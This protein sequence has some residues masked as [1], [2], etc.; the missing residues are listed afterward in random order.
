[1]LAILFVAAGILHFL[2]PQSYLKIMPAFFPAPLALVYL[3][4]AFEIL[5]GIGILVPRLRRWTG[6]GLIALL[7]AVFPAN[8]EMLWQNLRKEGLSLFSWLLIFRLPLQLV[9]IW[10]VHR[11]TG[12][13]RP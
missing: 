3:S 2:K 1:M 8:V 5:G 11:L 9:L 12:K 7:I 4:G 13:R 10:I 6:I